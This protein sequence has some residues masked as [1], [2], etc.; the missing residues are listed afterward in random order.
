MRRLYH[1]CYSSGN[2]PMFRNE[3][4]YR[5]G[6]NFLAL[7]IFKTE[8]DLLAD[9][10]MSNHVHFVVMTNRINEFVQSFR[11]YYSIYFNNKYTRNGRLGER[12]FFRAEIIG[13]RHQLA[14]ISYVL[15]NGFHHGL[16]SLPFGY[17]Y[18]S[19]RCYFKEDFGRDGVA[20]TIS[21]RPDIKTFLPRYSEFPDH[22]LM[23]KN[24]QF[25][26]ESFVQIPQVEFM[27]STPKAFLYNMTRLSGEKW[28]N[29]QKLDEQNTPPVTLDMIE[30]GT[31]ESLEKMLECEKTKFKKINKTDTELCTIIDTIILS[32]FRKS[33]VYCLNH[34]D[35]LKALQILTCE[36]HIN[37]KQAKRCLVF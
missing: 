33:S 3:E 12:S 15:R 6:V 5:S 35:K 1:V 21:S 4:D 16:C 10:F 23:D 22:Y 31:G 27:Y 25:I 7:S 2:E 24:G 14:A 34:S 37:E 28:E 19:V 36:M 9:S 20:P 30:Y 8:T 11:V 18:S 17:P 32:K 13:H 29:E 26:R